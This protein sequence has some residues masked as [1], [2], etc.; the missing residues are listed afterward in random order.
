MGFDIWINA[1]ATLF[2]TID[3][4]GLVPMF[5]ALTQGM[6]SAERFA[7]AIRAAIIAFVLL[8]V[9][10]LAGSL[11]LSTLGITL[12]AFRI[13]GGL[14]LF[15]IAFEMI[16]ERR[17]ERHEKSSSKAITRADIANIAAFPL[18]IPLIAGPGSISAVI[19]IAGEAHNSWPG[20]SILMAVIASV[21]GVM[22]AVF[23][24]VGVM[25]RVLGELGRM[26][27]TRLMGVLLAALAVQ[28]VADGMLAFI[29]HN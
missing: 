7:T 11:I 28:F 26:V 8:A 24:G 19:L 23:M 17:Q 1:F 5:A 21:L 2:V 6:S 4:I 3:P 29:N 20:I 22:V 16:F 14:L 12:D 15:Y 13:A 25:E 27:L 10:A 9:F 18:A